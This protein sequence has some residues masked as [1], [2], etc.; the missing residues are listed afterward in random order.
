MYCNSHKKGIRLQILMSAR[1]AARHRNLHIPNLVVDEVLVL[2]AAYARRPPIFRAKGGVNMPR[3]SSCHVYVRLREVPGATMKA[4]VC[5]PW[6]ER[7]NNHHRQGRHGKQHRS[8]TLIATRSQLMKA[9]GA[10]AL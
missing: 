4:A 1:A 8:G 7:R 10:G 5:Q 6:W 9:G 2:R 3:R